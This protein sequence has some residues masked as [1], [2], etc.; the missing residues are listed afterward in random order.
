M[1][2]LPIHKT[3]RDAFA[4]YLARHLQEAARLHALRDQLAHDAAVFDRSNMA[5][6]ITSSVLVFDPPHR[7]VLLIHHKV[8]RMWM[9]PGGHVERDAANLLASGLREVEEE[10]GLP[11]TSV[12]PL[13]HGKALDIDTHAIAARPAKGEGPHWH[14]DFLFLAVAAQPFDPVP[15]VE[16]VNGVEWLPIDD[17]LGIPG[18]RMQHLAP[19]LRQFLA[20]RT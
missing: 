3:T 18:A 6:H 15:Q 16:E 7:R 14:H 12:Q 2:Q 1:Q 4:A 17:F 11:A 5:G 9:Q 20:A 8:Y 13:L 19:K 10:T